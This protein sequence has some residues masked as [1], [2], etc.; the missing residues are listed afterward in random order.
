MIRHL[1]DIT[2]IGPDDVPLSDKKTMGVF[3]G[4]K[5]LDIKNENYKFVHGTYGIPEFGTGFVRRM[6]SR[7]RYGYRNQDSKCS[8]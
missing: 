8:P 2:G 5:S 4:L 3:N 6:S 7:Y 1:E